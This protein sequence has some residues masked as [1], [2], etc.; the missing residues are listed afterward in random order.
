VVWEEAQEGYST[1]LVS[2][3]DSVRDTPKKERKNRRS[4]KDKIDGSTRKERQ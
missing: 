4:V 2:T 1:V 3:G